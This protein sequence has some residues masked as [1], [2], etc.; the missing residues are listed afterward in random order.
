MLQIDIR[1]LVA[2]LTEFELTPSAED[3]DLDPGVFSDIRVEARIEFDTHEAVVSLACSAVTS[4]TCDRTAVDYEQPVRG[5]FTMLF[6]PSNRISGDDG[7]SSQ[8]VRPLSATDEEI[9]ITDIVRDTLLLSIPIRKIAPG[10]VDAEVPTEFGTPG[11]SELDPR[12]EAL[13]ALSS[14]EENESTDDK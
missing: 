10:A 4:L 7:E 5:N 8:E 13:K 14:E 2:G 11:E 3:V 6:A 12:W 9:E 1:N